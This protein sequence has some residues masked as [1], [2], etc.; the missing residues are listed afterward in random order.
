MNAW[1]RRQRGQSLHNSNSTLPTEKTSADHHLN[2]GRRRRRRRRCNSSPSTVQSLTDSSFHDSPPPPP[3]HLPQLDE[4]YAIAKTT[5]IAQDGASST[6]TTTTNIVSLGTGSF[7]LQGC[8]VDTLRK[9][10]PSG[11]VVETPTATMSMTNTTTSVVSSI[12]VLEEEEEEG[13]GG[14]N[15][16]PDLHKSPTEQTSSDE[17]D[18]DVEEEED[19]E[20]DRL[21]LLEQ[22]LPQEHASSSFVRVCDLNLHHHY[23][24]L[25]SSLTTVCPHN[26]HPGEWMAIPFHSNTDST[27]TVGPL[28]E[29]LAAMGLGTAM[30]AEIWTPDGKTKQH[31]L[32]TS[33]ATSWEGTTFCPPTAR[34]SESD[35]TRN[36]TTTA[37][38]S[39]A[40]ATTV[41]D[42]VLVWT[43]TLVNSYGSDIPAVRSA[44][45]MA[46]SAESL[47]DLLLDSSRVQEYN[48]MSLGRTDIQVL[49]SSSGTLSTSLLSS[50]SSLAKTMF[51]RTVE[52]KIVQSASR[53]PMLR[54]TLQFT[55]LLHAREYADGYLLVSRAVTLPN[56]SNSTASSSSAVV[57]SEILLG[58]NWI[59]RLSDHQCL[60]V[61]VNHVKSPLIPLLLA[62]RLGLQ[63]AVNFIH[64]VRA[65]CRQTQSTGGGST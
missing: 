59:R 34:P 58:V 10:S 12:V 21:A 40:I 18:E 63:A 41:A 36:T 43:G 37:G 47:L 57:V 23:T 14:C 16:S 39:T 7:T 35:T 29:S 61:T 42:H 53:P 2:L 54:K 60:L 55:T 27:T 22:T 32:A 20:E 56:G 50:S 13:D 62:K 64:D 15:L 11:A 30:N 33:G 3:P 1:L 5:E 6:I 4:S 44:A 9:S 51:P 49:E 65:S 17:D 31:L 38:S 52:S 26:A 19:D 25:R 45:V 28:M 24:H 48:A 46:Q 8:V